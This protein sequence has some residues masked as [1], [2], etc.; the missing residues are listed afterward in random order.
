M[1]Y[2][3]KLKFILI[4]SAKKTKSLANQKLANTCQL[5][6]WLRPSF[7][8]K[9]IFKFNFK[10]VA[11]ICYPI[12]E[13]YIFLISFKSKISWI[14][15]IHYKVTR[16]SSMNIKLIFLRANV[17]PSY[18]LNL[19]CVYVYIGHYDITWIYITQLFHQSFIMSQ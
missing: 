14:G 3:F 12:N 11:L 9:W 7:N 13:I 10:A 2:G 4:S 19:L 8:F 6:D 15:K 1:P 18:I 16:I 17:V 5:Y